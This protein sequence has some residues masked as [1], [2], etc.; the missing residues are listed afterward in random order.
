MTRRRGTGI[1]AS[2]EALTRTNAQQAYKISGLLDP[3]RFYPRFGPLPAVIEVRNQ[4]G[5][6]DAVGR[7][8]TLMLSD[9]G[10]VVETITDTE[11][12]EL[13]GYELSEFQKLFG[14]LVSGGCGTCDMYYRR[15]PERSI[16]WLLGRKAG[17]SVEKWPADATVQ[18]GYRIVV[19]LEP[20]TLRTHRFHNLHKDALVTMTLCS[21]RDL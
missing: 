8:R 1:R 12:P 16:C 13:F 2:A 21:D 4:S 9:G 14:M 7:T 17:C 5:D 19:I 10:H 15:S 18:S 6:W 3:T 20:F 11:V